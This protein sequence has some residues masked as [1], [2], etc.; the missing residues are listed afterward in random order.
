[1][2]VMHRVL[3]RYFVMRVA[4]PLRSTLVP[5]TTLF[6][7]PEGRGAL[8]R[9]AP[10]L[11][12]RGPPHGAALARILRGAAAAGLGARASAAPCGG[13]REVG[14]ADGGTPVTVAARMLSAV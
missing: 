13:A 12:A 9:R 2:R 5:Y 3:R 7:S 10:L 11:A 4:G 8:I 6:R 1:V 14:S